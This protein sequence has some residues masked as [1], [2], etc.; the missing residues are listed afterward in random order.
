MSDF[1]YSDILKEYL[2]V[3]KKFIN[4]MNGVIQSINHENY[5]PIDINI[6]K[7]KLQLKETSI[8]NVIANYGVSSN[9]LLHCDNN[10][11]KSKYFYF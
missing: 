9:M 3:Y 2:L 11:I 6:N 8:T 10:F 7:I 1:Y 5:L 4:H